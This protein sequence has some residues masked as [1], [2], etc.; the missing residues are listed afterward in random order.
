LDGVKKKTKHKM[1]CIS[2]TKIIHNQD[3]N[4]DLGE[5][6]NFRQKKTKIHFTLRDLIYYFLEKFNSN[7]LVITRTSVAKI[8]IFANYRGLFIKKIIYLKILRMLKILLNIKTP[9]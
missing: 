9:K 7:L 5:E 6:I 1:K 8:K 4:F 3:N 2:R